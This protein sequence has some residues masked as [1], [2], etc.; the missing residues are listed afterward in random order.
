MK[1]SLKA[2]EKRV[3]SVQRELS[4]L[5]FNERV[6]FEASDVKNPLVSRVHFLGIFSS[7]LDE[8]FK[9]RIAS[10]NRE[11]KALR[12][13]KGN[14]LDVIHDR[15]IELQWEFDR[16][17]ENTK[18]ALAKVGVHFKNERQLSTEQKLYVDHYF[19]DEIRHHIIPI[20]MSSSMPLPPLKDNA[21]YLVVDV[22]L[23]DKAKKVFALIEVPDSISRWV[24]LPADKGE[25]HVMFLEDVIRYNLKK[26]FSIYS[27]ASVKA[28]DVKVV[29]DAEYEIEN[30]FSKSVFDKISK[31]IQ[32][33][34]KGDYVR[35]N[36]DHE[37]PED[38][39]HLLLTKTKI[40]NPQNII[41]GGRYHN[42]K[43]LLSFPDFGNP[44]W[45]YPKI[46][47]LSHPAFKKSINILD[48][49]NKKDV[50]LHFP[51]Q[52]FSHILDLLRAAAIDPQVRTIRISMYRIA[53]DSHILHA[54]VNAAK[55]GKKVVALVEVQARFD[56]AHNLEITKMLQAA[57]V[58][59]I[60]GIP[61]LKVHCKVFQISR[62]ING[63]TVRITHIGTGNFHE[64]T[65]RIYSDTSLLTTNLDLG[66]EVRSLFHFFESNYH[67]PQFRHLVVSPFNTR[68]KLMD[69]IGEEIK[70]AKKGKKS[71]VVIKVNNL[72]DEGIIKKLLE[73]GE[74]GVEVKLVVRGVCLL[75]PATQN[76]K[77][78]ISMRSILGRY[79][80]HSRVF[81]FGVGK[82]ERILI[83]SA[84]MMV[85]NLDYRIEVL[86][87]ILDNELRAEL[88][89]WLNLQFDQH[90]KARC[91]ESERIN[92]L[93]CSVVQSKSFD[94]Q[95]A[96][97]HLLTQK[98]EINK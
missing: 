68:R 83:G 91:L 85:R 84:D 70:E 44:D 73:A 36:F 21:L 61:G 20:L 87:P 32:Q 28:Y 2:M 54:L 50:L 57:G 17:F 67:R 71:L 86:A 1:S 30:D 45:I 7:N 88:K 81:V 31:S 76:Q 52:R 92:H 40:K 49:F 94:T 75:Q 12:G 38:L 37:I 90:A 23:K 11:L 79:L 77:K 19:D 6:L 98:S 41:P 5:Q 15:V 16:I 46:K 97:Y 96:Y 53:H 69:W 8:F 25:K 51:Y 58:K 14:P 22:V 10:L 66:R 65:A 93:V 47:S 62:K 29:R 74:N 9:V 55:N 60:P 43:D 4:W 34:S 80:E 24:V 72:V 18:K 89:E 78:N 26:I 64:K 39:L 48:T 56:E 35:I 3:I 27:I 13:K 33:R 59:V 82:R 95:D 63:K 42:K